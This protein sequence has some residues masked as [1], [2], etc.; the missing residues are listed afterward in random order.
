MK[1]EIISWIGTPIGV[2][3]TALQTNEIMQYIQLGLTILSTAVALA[4]TIWNWWRKAKAD[5][6]ITEDEVDEI[7][8]DVNDIVN[9]DNDKKEK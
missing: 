4:F 9:K 6:K 1:K 5:G 8:N 7:V 3:C 2:I